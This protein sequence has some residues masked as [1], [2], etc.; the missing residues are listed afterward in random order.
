M[1]TALIPRTTVTE[2]CAHRD[3]SMSVMRDAVA[4]M[5]QGQDMA[6]QSYR[7][8]Q[9][10]FE[11]L[12]PGGKLVA[13]LPATVEFGESKAHDT[14]RAWAKKHSDCYGSPFRDLPMESFASS[15]TRINTVYVVLHK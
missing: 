11:F 4:A 1:E 6:E 9:L 10:G 13:I 3:A 5:V 7:H 15:G 8:A 14:F 12:R 2:V